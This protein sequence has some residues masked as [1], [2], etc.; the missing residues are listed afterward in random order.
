MISNQ[1]ITQVLGTRFVETLRRQY[2]S[3]ILPSAAVSLASP[4]SRNAHIA[5]GIDVAWSDGGDILNF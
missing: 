5:S 3:S 1:Q 4:S 2:P